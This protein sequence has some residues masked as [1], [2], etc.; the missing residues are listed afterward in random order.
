[1]AKKKAA[2]AVQPQG[3]PP[4]A[5]DHLG[6]APPL[7]TSSPQS[8]TTSLTSPSSHNTHDIA[9]LGPAAPPLS[10]TEERT[11]TPK[12]NNAAISDL[13][14][15]LDDHVR[16]VLTLPNQ[17]FTRSYRHD[18]VRLALGWSSVAVA[19]ATGYYGYVIP[20]HHST[21]W[22]SVGVVLYVVLNTV[23]ALYVAFVENNTIFEGKRRTLA[24]RISTERLTISTSSPYPL[25]ALTLSYSRS[26]S[27]GKALLHRATTHL[28]R[29]CADMFDGEGRLAR[30]VVERWVAEGLRE[31]QGEHAAGGAGAGE[32]DRAR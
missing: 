25:Y 27:G 30:G 6:A 8:T 17:A 18:D 19:A 20:F 1:M 12:I 3:T 5:A 16:L 13:K 7:S 9:A 32:K 21:F 23:L 31:V 15:T 29:P 2:R 4:L 11:P 28:V 22:V 24:S 10:T 14:H 26:S